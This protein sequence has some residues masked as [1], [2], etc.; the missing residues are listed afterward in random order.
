MNLLDF[1]SN[2]VWLNALLFAVA[3]GGVWKSGAMLS[4]YV[5]LLA[6]RTGIGKAFAGALLLGGATSLPELATTVTAAT[7]GAAELAGTNL[8]GGVVMQIAVL[9]LIDAVALR[10]KALTF[11][12]PQPALL[13]QG[14]MLIFMI[15]LSVVALSSGEL[16][17]IAGVGF[18]PLLIGLAYIGVLWMIYRYEGAARWEPAGEVGQPPESAR[19]LQ[20]QRE[21]NFRGAS[22]KGVALRFALA[23][24]TVLS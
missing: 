11:F 20:D 1:T 6:D 2:P 3:A 14:V 5:D 12:S 9:A 4:R 8:L 24:L 15:A 18:W 17:T 19:D 23:A 10:G 16:F 22:T 13:M 7:S 21:Q